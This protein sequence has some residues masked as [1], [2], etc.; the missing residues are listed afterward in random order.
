MGRMDANLLMLYVGIIVNGPKRNTKTLGT[1]EFVKSR[2]VKV[3]ANHHLLGF[4]N[5]VVDMFS[6]GNAACFM[7]NSMGVAPKGFGKN[8]R[9]MAVTAITGGGK[10]WKTRNA[11]RERHPEEVVNALLWRVKLS[12]QGVGDDGEE[13]EEDHEEDGRDVVEDVLRDGGRYS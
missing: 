12:S 1:D 7:R 8:R 5:L 4:V 10:E 3:Q 11:R 13:V 9:R 2:V 6:L